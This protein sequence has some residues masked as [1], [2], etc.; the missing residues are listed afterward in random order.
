M[1]PSLSLPDRKPRLQS[2]MAVLLSG[3][4][5]SGER[6]AR[7][8]R[9][10]GDKRTGDEASDSLSHPYLLCPTLGERPVPFLGRRVTNLAKT[11]GRKAG[12][13]GRVLSLQPQQGT[14]QPTL[15]DCG[16]D[17]SSTTGRS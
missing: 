11:S 12:G 17:S 13:P 5:A 8:H 3:R 2:V 6:W 9:S 4:R 10:P 1:E 15:C 14:Q 7:H 16:A